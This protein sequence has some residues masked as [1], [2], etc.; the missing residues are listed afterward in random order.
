MFTDN[1]ELSGLIAAQINADK[2]IIL[3]SVPGVYDGHPNDPNSRLISIIDPKERGWPEVSTVTSTQGRGGMSSKLN[4]SRKM[5]DLGVT[6]H[7]ATVA[8]PQV[9]MRI[10]NG[11]KLGTT[12][13]PTKKKS[14]IKR[15]MA[16]NEGKENASIYINSCL[17]DILKENKRVLSILPVGIENY[18][19]DFKKGDLIDILAPDENKIGIGIA[20]Y[21]AE[22]LREYLG[23]KGKPALIHYDHL[24]IKIVL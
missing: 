17:F 5:S 19:G 3:T 22:K 10:L 2:L 24:H 12:I 1:D 15:W 21:D 8:E 18:K 4:T 14:N 11:E 9:I 23:V 7:I 16:F 20:R 6:T 13:L